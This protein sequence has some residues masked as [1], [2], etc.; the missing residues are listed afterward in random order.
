MKFRV[1]LEGLPA[2][3]RE[4]LVKLWAERDRAR[5]KEAQEN[6]TK[7]AAI[8]RECAVPGATKDGFGPMT[9]ARDPYL[10]A[11]DRFK[12]GDMCYSDPEF[13][14]WL[15]RHDERVHVP[16]APTKIQVGWKGAA[17]NK[18]GFRGQIVCGPATTQ[19]RGGRPLAVIADSG[20]RTVRF[21]KSY[22]ATE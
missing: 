8:Y 13:L 11:R 2:N 14:P 10:A 20:P 18:G 7:I 9:M 5:W 16:E 6:Q 17:R 4:Q 21:H 19:A 22:T 15:K 1:N 12:H 3:L